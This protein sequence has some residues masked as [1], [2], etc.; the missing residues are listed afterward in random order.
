MSNRTALFSRHQPGGV[1]TIENLVEHPGNVW[2]VNSADG[3]DGAGYGRNP[4]A[5]F[6]TADSL[7]LTKKHVQIGFL[8]GVD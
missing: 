8:H 3:T 7:A 5:P 1:W 6:A 2:F 4:D